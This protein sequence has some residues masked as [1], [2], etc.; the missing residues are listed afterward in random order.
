M[1]IA[2]TLNIVDHPGAFIKLLIINRINHDNLQKR[3]KFTLTYKDNEKNRDI[4][5]IRT[6]L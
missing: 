1:P 6:L 2:Y 5:K 3:T 4:Q